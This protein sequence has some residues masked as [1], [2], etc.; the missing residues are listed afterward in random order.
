MYVGVHWNIHPHLLYLFP[1][2]SDCIY[3]EFK[4]KP[5]SN[6]FLDA[7]LGWYWIRMIPLLGGGY[8]NTLAFQHSWP[9]CI[10]FSS[11]KSHP[12][13]RKTRRTSERAKSG[14]IFLKYSNRNIWKQRF[15]HC[16]LLVAGCDIV[17]VR[18]LQ[19][20]WCMVLGIIPD[21]YSYNRR[22]LLL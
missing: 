13:G 20:I 6:W 1:H 8:L 14:R 2:E 3:N 21:R 15:L 18:L 11:W 5:T 7:R 22:R 4:I 17:H 19:W 12:F 16:W 10:P 9:S